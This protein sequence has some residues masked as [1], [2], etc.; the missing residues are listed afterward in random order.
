[1]P[2]RASHRRVRRHAV[3][4]VAE[5]AEATEVCRQTVV[6]WIADRGLP[7]DRSM[8]PWL[9]R[10]ADLKRFLDERRRGARRPLSAGEIYCLPCRAAKRPAMGVADYRRKTETSG[11]LV[12]LCPDC[13]RLIHRVVR[14]DNLRRV[15]GD[16]DVALE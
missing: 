2:K 8:R 6:R 16:L 4:T 5:A 15:A 12:G 13:E 3:Y 11:V 9:I 14:R 1:M 10:G 7:A